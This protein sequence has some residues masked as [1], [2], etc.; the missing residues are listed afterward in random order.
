MRWDQCKCWKNLRGEKILSA[1]MNSK[2]T[3]KNPKIFF[4]HRTADNNK[5]EG[6]PGCYYATHTLAQP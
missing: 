6:Q 1:P 4:Y 5:N 2:M 3:K